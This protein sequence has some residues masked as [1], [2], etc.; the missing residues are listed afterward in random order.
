MFFDDKRE[1]DFNIKMYLELWICNAQG[2]HQFKIWEMHLQFIDNNFS[3][4]QILT[5]H[6]SNGCHR[7]I[8]AHELVEPINYI[9]NVSLISVTNHPKNNFFEPLLILGD[10]G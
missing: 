1:R 2:I 3:C 5:F 6:L 9:E 7:N 10:C 4:V 8:F